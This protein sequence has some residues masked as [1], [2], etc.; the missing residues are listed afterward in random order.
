MEKERLRKFLIVLGISFAWSW[1]MALTALYNPGWAYQRSGDVLMLPPDRFVLLQSAAVWEEWVLLSMWVVAT[2]AWAFVFG[3]MPWKTT[4]RLIATGGVWGL[5][6]WVA[7]IFPVLA[8]VWL[9]LA[10]LYLS[11]RITEENRV[12]MREKRIPNFQ[13]VPF[14]KA[15]LL[16]LG[17]VISTGLWHGW[18]SAVYGIAMLGAGLFFLVTVVIEVICGVCGPRIQRRR[19]PDPPLVPGS[20]QRL[21]EIE[22][23]TTSASTDVP[24]TQI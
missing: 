3:N 21:A 24:P 6:S 1:V 17:T 18:G 11:G 19:D 4:A 23:V 22:P 20:S 9:V 10:W 2:I 12:R 15:S 8:G 5:V 13:E 7:G 14:E 16:V